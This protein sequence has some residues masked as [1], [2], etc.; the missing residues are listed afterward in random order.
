VLHSGIDFQ[1]LISAAIVALAGVAMLGPVYRATD[2]VL[3]WLLAPAV[4]QALLAVSIGATT[5]ARVPVRD[6]APVMLLAILVLAAFGYRA[7]RS[8]A[9]RP[10]GA[11]LALCFALPVVV[12][13]PYFVYGLADYAGSRLP[14]GWSYAAYGQY[15][16]NYPRGAEGGL[17]PLYQ[18]SAHL[19]GTRN[20]SSA[21]LGFFSLITHPGETQSSSGLFLALTLFTFGSSCAAYAWSRQCTFRETALIV[22]VSTLSGWMINVVVANNYDNLAALAAFPALA[23]VASSFRKDGFGPWMVFAAILAG[24]FYTYPELVALVLPI[25]GLI[26]VEQMWR[27][28]IRPG[29]ATV[30]AGVAFLILTGPYLSTGLRFILSQAAAVGQTGV[31][32]GEG[33]FPGLLT[34]ATQASAFWSLGGET[35]VAPYRS[36]QI[37]GAVSLFALLA[38]GVV[39]LVRGR[40][41]GLLAALILPLAGAPYMIFVNHYSYGAYK[42][43]VMGWWAL[44]FVTVKGGS[45][46]GLGWVI[47]IV[48]CSSIPGVAAARAVRETRMA[49]AVG[50]ERFR[51][52]RE[53]VPL[54][55]GTPI[56][57]LVEDW[58]A[59]Q[60]AVYFLRDAPIQLADTDVYLAMPHVRPLLARAKPFP[61]SGVR[62]ILTDAVDPGP[63]VE[64]G[65]WTPVWRNTAYTLWDTGERNWAI[66]TEVGGTI[67]DGTAKGIDVTAGPV[68]AKVFARR[69]GCMELA[70]TLANTSQTA[71]LEA[72]F[73]SRVQLRAGENT[74]TIGPVA[75]EASGAPQT[76]TTLLTHLTSR[77]SALVDMVN[78]EN[79]NGLEQV[80]GQPFFWLGGAPARVHLVSST[81][82]VLIKADLGIGPSLG[83]AETTRRLRIAV[84]AT[85]F[86]QT[87]VVGNGPVEIPVVVP[88]GNTDIVLE[89]LDRPTIPVQPN[90]D[91]RPLVLGVRNLTAESPQTNC[92]SE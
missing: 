4:V 14:D 82:S 2:P 23:A 3:G 73:T 37:A 21:L 78:V 38:S 9:F 6:L 85:G 76:P 87:I 17:A 69:D 88:I 49:P 66:A 86:S 7:A 45:P 84:D 53:A 24:L 90:G 51:E 56:G 40:E 43:L 81:T 55:K 22:L 75:R 18:Y 46:R 12:L 34:R 74:I 54:A 8:L 15:L 77:I 91:G 30:L 19:V 52:V 57:I 80:G 35:G 71:R 20:V 58:E 36:I 41:V 89:A 27:R 33:Y 64:L 70:A 48:V 50:M 11:L 32:P 62:F 10:A 68:S 29:V 79:Q 26:V 5:A 83:P 25:C 31:R 16:W 1:Y 72:P 60:W 92:Q 13:L 65:D 44:M 59:S 28:R 63:I 39:R 67:A 61:W 47:T 42:L